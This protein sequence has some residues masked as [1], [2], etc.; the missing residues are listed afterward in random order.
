MRVVLSD[1][2]SV[3]CDEEGGLNRTVLFSFFFCRC[4]GINKALLSENK[5]YHITA[6]DECQQ[7]VSHLHIYTMGQE[8][9]TAIQ[10]E[11]YIMESYDFLCI[12]AGT[13]SVFEL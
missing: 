11:T 3:K 5:F 8:K 1:L 13:A 6:V 4:N 10:T 9:R 7:Y 12:Q 2:R